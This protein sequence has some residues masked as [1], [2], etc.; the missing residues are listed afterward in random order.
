M[1]EQ[2]QNVFY[3][4]LD[5]VAYPAAMLLAAPMLM[6]TLGVDGYGL[7]SVM[8]AIVSAASIVASG[9]G[10]AAIK[11]VSRDRVKDPAAVLITVRVLFLVSAALAVLLEADRRQP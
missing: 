1:K 2:M 4:V 7:W 3:G 5:Y 9:F 10:D 8:A 11:L 6:H